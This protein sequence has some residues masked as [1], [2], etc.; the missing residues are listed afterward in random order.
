MTG[1]RQNAS[2]SRAETVDALADGRRRSGAHARRP[3]AG[4]DAV[5]ALQRNAGNAAVNA[6]MAARLTRPPEQAVS[7]I[8]AAVRELR[9]DE[10]A[11]ETVEKGLKAAKSAGVPVELEGPKP[12]PSALAVTRTGFG[13]EAVAPKKPVPPAKPV[14]KVS[15][16]GKAAATRAKAPGPRRGATPTTAPSGGRGRGRLR[17]GCSCAAGGRQATPAPGRA[18]PGAAPNAIPASTTSPAVS[19]ASP[20]PRRRTRPRRRKPRRP[21]TRRSPRRTIWRD[22]RRRRR[23]TRWKPSRSVPST[24]RRSSRR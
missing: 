21:R 22:R 3:L 16:L 4:A 11:I 18:D 8:D 6:L 20:T 15:P 2:A 10:P 23:S 24:R 19:R 7:D 13:P 1:G 5:L 12:P 9:R 17:A 14:P